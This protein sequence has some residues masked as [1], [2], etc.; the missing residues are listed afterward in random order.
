MPANGYRMPKETAIEWLNE[1]MLVVKI[2]SVPSRKLYKS[3]GVRCRDVW[4][5]IGSLQGSES[6]DYPTQKPSSLLERIIQSSTNEG[7]IVADFFCG[8]GS[9][10]AVAEK[11]GRK[12]ITSDIRKIFNPYDTQKINN[13]ST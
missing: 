13:R 3:E 2:G 5:D 11:L 9:T 8:S 6:L 10:A 7:D 4:A 12:W 1:G